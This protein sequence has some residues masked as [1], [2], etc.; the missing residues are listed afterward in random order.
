MAADT[1]ISLTESLGP[2]KAASAEEIEKIKET[3]DAVRVEYLPS[4]LCGF[5]YS[6][7]PMEVH[8]KNNRIIR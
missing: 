8:V 5:G 7:P 1:K 4:T 2:L 6:S 3:K